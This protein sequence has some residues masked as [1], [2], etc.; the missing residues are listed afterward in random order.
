[1]KIMCRASYR[2]GALAFVVAGL[3]S[4]CSP[5]ASAATPITI[6][7]MGWDPPGP[8]NSAIQRFEATHRNIQVKYTQIPFTQYDARLNTMEVAGTTPDI[9][10][11]EEYNANLFGTKGVLKPLNPFLRSNALG[12]DVLPS[13]LFRSNGTTW[14]IGN[15]GATIALY[16]NPALLK[17]AGVAPPS[18]DPT[19]PWTWSQFVAAAKKL[20]VDASGKHPGDKGFDPTKIRVYGTN[21]PS[22]WTGMLPLV[23]ST[24][25]GFFNHDATRFTLP[26]PT[27]AAVV[28]DIANLALVD[29][30]A[31]TPTQMAGFPTL[32]AL[33][34]TGK[35]AMAIDGTWDMAVFASDKFHEGVAA[36][37]M[38]KKPQD[39]V[40][41]AAY[42]ISK[43]TANPAESWAVIRGMLEDPA[44]YQL[45][46]ELPPFKSWY[47]NPTK[48]ALWADNA[49]HPAGFK[50][51]IMGTVTNP[52][53]GV[54]G[55]NVYV[56]QFGKMMDNYVTPGLDPVWAGKESAS[57]ALKSIAPQ[58]QP[59]VSGVWK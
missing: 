26:D 54:Q 53:I 58:V 14:G 49:A 40:W 37:P 42:S 50:E 20:T 35:M 8:Y 13:M 46:A 11:L 6:K 28:Q 10:E 31:P 39:S 30:V 47:T 7:F 2:A 56:K 18:A 22:S 3:V 19:H 16:Y 45:G 34:A 24:G 57:A 52:E 1:M 17:K 4:L 48:I 41:A 44:F 23:R 15:G 33:V 51:A 36:I 9:I 29:H 27:A 12:S 25:T 38:F 5:A 59:L 43:T 21:E 32:P 55:E